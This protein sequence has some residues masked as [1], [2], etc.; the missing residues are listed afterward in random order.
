[1][2]R[3]SGYNGDDTFDVAEFGTLESLA[4]HLVY[5]ALL[6]AAVGSREPRY[7]AE[8]P[9]EVENIP[10]IE[11]HFCPHWRHVESCLY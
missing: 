8:Q 1:M 4:R 6:G 2:G 10:H 5:G 11:L 7:V 3:F 9:T